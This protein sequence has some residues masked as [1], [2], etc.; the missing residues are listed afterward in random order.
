MFSL[1]QSF[2][3]KKLRNEFV[4]KNKHCFICGGVE[5][6]EVHHII[7]KKINPDLYL[8]ESNLIVLCDGSDR[9]KG[10]SCHR[11]FGHFG[12]YRSRWNENILE[13]AKYFRKMFC[14]D[15]IR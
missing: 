15:K 12:C 9:F 1:L 14:T 6:L 8:E 13:D 11:I 4:K 3:W 10:L 5:N 2:T 7:P